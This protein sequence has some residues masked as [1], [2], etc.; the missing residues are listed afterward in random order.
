MKTKQ[1]IDALRK[2]LS[3]Q[4]KRRER[5][6]EAKRKKELLDKRK[7]LVNELAGELRKEVEDHF[8]EYGSDSANG[9]CLL[10]RPLDGEN[11]EALKKA[12]SCLN[13]E[14]AKGGYHFATIIKP[15]RLRPYAYSHKVNSWMWT[16]EPGHRNDAYFRDEYF[17]AGERWEDTMVHLKKMRPK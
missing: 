12:V 3:K 10:L 6:K 14:L 4:E 16:D 2:N 17:P 11:I 5:Q 1:E 8:I 7:R 9:I 13:K 15:G